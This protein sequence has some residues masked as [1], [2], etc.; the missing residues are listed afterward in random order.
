M[1]RNRPVEVIRAEIE[2][3]Q[4]ELELT[5]RDLVS[6]EE[7]IESWVKILEEDID[8]LHLELEEAFKERR[9]AE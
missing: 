3:A 4:E 2:D 6:S 1:K 9:F 7:S 8:Y 5:E